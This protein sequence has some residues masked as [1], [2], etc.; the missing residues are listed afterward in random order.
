MGYGFW[1]WVLGGSCF[2]VDDAYGFQIPEVFQMRRTELEEGMRLSSG[3]DGLNT[4]VSK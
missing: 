2:W 3:G 1:R 4:R